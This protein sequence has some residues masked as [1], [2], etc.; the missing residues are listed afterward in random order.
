MWA[1][2]ADRLKGIVR[3][4]L[5]IGVCLINVNGIPTIADDRL[6]SPMDDF[7]I[8]IGSR[9][10]V[11]VPDIHGDLNAL[12]VILKSEK[13]IDAEGNWVGESDV[14][15][16]LGDL[17]DREPYS[18][19]VMDLVMRLQSQAADR[20]GHVEALLGN[21]ELMVS[22][23]D[24]R[25][26]SKLE[27]RSF[28]DYGD[29]FIEGHLMAYS[30][31]SIYSRWIAN[32][33]TMIQIIPDTGKSFLL[34][35]AGLGR[36]IFNFT[37]DEVNQGLQE[38][39]RYYQGAG[40]RPSNKK[41]V[42]AAIRD[43]E[44]G[45]LWDRKM[46]NFAMSREPNPELS[47]EEIFVYLKELGAD[48]VIVGHTPTN[49]FIEDRRMIRQ[50]PNLGR[51][52]ILADTGVA[53]YYG[54]RLSSLVIEGGKVQARYYRRPSFLMPLT[55]RVHEQCFGPFRKLGLS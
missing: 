9:R 53:S 2:L 55:K 38:W 52:L 44:F 48:A 11:I 13:L 1:G 35:H 8:R 41:S 24:D 15:V 27:K 23:G 20:G 36:W 51:R 28:R 43:N 22:K 50:T 32:R 42:L 49:D 39:I 34:V 7:R 3:F 46:V 31:D 16:F 37:P 47:R 14:L 5:C 12:E 17:I 33:R 29:D 10:V 21:H 30:G 45:P 25:Y 26:V 19:G 40:E 54:G 6:V 4:S 18:R